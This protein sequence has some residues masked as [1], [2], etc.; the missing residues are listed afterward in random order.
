MGWD[1]R[2]K[3]RYDE[4]HGWGKIT[5]MRW[6]KWN[7]RKWNEMRWGANWGEMTWHHVK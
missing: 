6:E 5:W 1:G 3:V 4:M 2:T 7:D